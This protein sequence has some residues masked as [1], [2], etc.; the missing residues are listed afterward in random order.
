MPLLMLGVVAGETPLPLPLRA[1]VRPLRPLAR[2]PRSRIDC[3]CRWISRSPQ[4]PPAA[5]L[6]LPPA[7]EPSVREGPPPTAPRPPLPPG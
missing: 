2:P 3:C 4:L 5:V 1:P 6:A 7:H